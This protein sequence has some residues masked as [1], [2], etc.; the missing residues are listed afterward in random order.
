MGDSVCFVVKFGDCLN[1]NWTKNI[2]EVV[3]VEL[4]R[5]SLINEMNNGFS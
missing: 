5:N 1:F 4:E 3:K 2:C